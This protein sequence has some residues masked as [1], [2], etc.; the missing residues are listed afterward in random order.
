MLTEKQFIAIAPNDSIVCVNISQT[1]NNDERKDI[2]DCARHY[3][4]LNVQRAEKA[5]HVLAITR[6]IVVGVFK[7]TRW[8]KSNHPKY[9]NRYEFEGIEEKNSPYLNKCVW[10]VLNPKAQNPISYI[11]L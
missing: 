4:V 3:W 8:Y 2:Y 1:Y 6:G 5:T 11:N 9:N 10:N 7:P